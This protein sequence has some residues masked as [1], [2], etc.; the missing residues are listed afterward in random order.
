[1]GQAHQSRLGTYRLQ[2][3]R[4]FPFDAATDLVSYL[5]QLGVSHI[6]SSPVLSA[7]AGSAHGYDV[8]NPTAVNAELGGEEGFAEFSRSLQAEH[9]GLVLD[10]VPNHM[11]IGDR[12]NLWWWDVLQNGRM[13]RFAPYFDVDWSPVGASAAN[14]DAVLVPVLGDHYG[15]VLEAGDISLERE[16]GSLIVRYF[17]HVFP[18][19]PPS[20]AVLYAEAGAE[21]SSDYQV[22]LA[23]ALATLPPAEPNDAQTLLRRHRQKEV[24]RKQLEELWQREPEVA[25][26]IDRVVHRYSNDPDLLDE[27]LGKQN[28]R[29]A[30]WRVAKQELGYRRFFDVTELAGLQVEDE[31]VFYATHERIIEWLDAGVLDG[32]R[33]D[34]A[35]GLV[36][37][38]QYLV[39]LRRHAPTSWILVEKILEDAEELP[40]SW[41]VEGT[42]GYEFLTLVGGLFISP[43]GEEPLT[44]LYNE[45]TGETHSFSEIVREKKRLVLREVLGGDVNRLA[46]HLRELCERHRR[47]RDFTWEQL[48]QTVIELAVAFP[49]YRTYLQPDGSIVRSVDAATIEHVIAMVREHA[50]EPIDEELLTFLR[51]VLL[52]R[53]GLPESREFIL[54]LQ[55]L[56]GPVMA[57]S[58]E[59]TA[60]Y[61][62]HR[63]ISLNEVGGNPGR[64]AITPEVFHAAAHRRQQRRPYSLLATST[65]DTKRSE[66]V[67]LRIHVLSE[68]PDAWRAFVERSAARAARYKDERLID[69]HTEYL[70]YQTLIGAWPISVERLQQYIKKAVREAK[71]HTSWITVNEAYESGLENFIDALLGDAEFVSDLEQFLLPIVSAARVHSLAQT[72]IKCTAP[73]VP[74]FYQGS[75]LWTDSLVDPDNRRPVDYGLRRAMLEQVVEGNAEQM[76]LEHERGLTKLFLIHRTL[77]VRARQERALGATAGY[78]ALSAVGDRAHHVLAYLRGERALVVVPRLVHILNGRWGET[79]LEVPQGQWTNVFDRRTVSGGRIDIQ[80]LLSSFPVALLLKE[81]V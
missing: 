54:R 41:P 45:F 61:C 66:D 67:R 17:D 76:M 47:H 68:M 25:R 8:V 5:R 81:D 73:G 72:L 22:F 53:K 69:R 36:D 55:Q 65:H 14:V 19:S 74:D 64:F 56:T 75:E 16:G 10:I 58:V 63:L 30:F 52:L 23:D 3:H 77:A 37:P 50:K 57:K 21:C 70:L 32:L 12:A 27:L 71:A 24:V 38:E 48:R 78:R 46:F 43:A 18:V 80:D 40:D 42:T 44:K 79:S 33:I 29:L 31:D 20:A 4:D 28:Y 59:D 9:L 60:F 2:L 35:D 62:Y 6:Y 11:A 15:R 13:S 51:D 1:M 34:H 26:A 49:I 7:V 39:R